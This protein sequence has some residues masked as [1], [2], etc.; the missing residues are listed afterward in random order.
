MDAMSSHKRSKS[1]SK[2]SISKLPDGIL[3]RI[4]SF[5]P[6]KD[7]VKTSLLSRRWEY[8]WTSIPNLEFKE[9]RPSDNFMPFVDRAISLHIS[10]IKK[11]TLESYEGGDE[12]CIKRLIAAVVRR[13]VEELHIDTDEPQEPLQLPQCL[14]VSASLT[15]LDL[16]ICCTLKFPPSISLSSLKH[17][18]FEYITFTNDVSTQRFFSGCPALETICFDKCNWTNLCSVGLR[19]PKLWKLEIG[20]NGSYK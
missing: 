6:T 19:A 15:R 7:A 8:L 5:L 9:D 3:Q 18:R 11:F 13:N 16:S 20:N 2:R 4:L 14:F 10:D 12:P 17:L 1:N